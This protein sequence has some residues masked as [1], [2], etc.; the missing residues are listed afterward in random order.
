MGLFDGVKVIDFTHAYSGPFCTMNLADY[1]AEVI[2][3]ERIDGGDQ[4][5]TWGPFKNDYSAYYA[6]FNRGKQS[7]TLNIASEEGQKIIFDLV[8][9]ADIVVSNFKAGTLEKY[10]IGYDAIKEIKPDIIYASLSGFGTTG[11][12]SKYAAYDNVIQAM[13]GVMDV[14]GFPDKG[15]TKIGPA[16]GDSYSGLVLLLGIVI[17]YYSRLKTGKGQKV[18]AT[19]LGA[20]F[21]TLEYP[22]LE[23]ANTGKVLSRTGNQSSYYAPGDVYKVK[24]GFVAL[25][26]KNDVMWEVFC[27]ALKLNDMKV[28]DN[29]KTNE[30]R[31]KN[32]EALTVDIE[33]ALSGRTMKEVETALSDTEVPV[34]GV[35]NIAEALENEHLQARNMVITVDDPVIGALKLVGNPIHLSENP[36]ILEVPSPTLGQNTEQLMEALGYT[37][38]EIFSLKDKGVI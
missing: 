30:M 7:I 14:N 34:S 37:K 17:A 10:G 28:N 16:I 35:K 27:D 29:Y 21:T 20:L 38:K 25:S 31:L 13:S 5:R 9:E 3:V 26:V 8:K 15:P 24:D 36:P 18:D 1:G 33:Q 12:L 32:R 2:K 22:I 4:A 19:M 23:Y 11:E 6:S